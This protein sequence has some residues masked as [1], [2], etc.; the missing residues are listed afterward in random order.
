MPMD[1][2]KLN[3]R[4]RQF[5]KNTVQF[6]NEQPPKF[7]DKDK[8]AESAS[9]FSQASINSHEYIEAKDKIRQ[10]T[11]AD[12]PRIT[13]RSAYSP[14]DNAS[15]LVDELSYNKLNEMEQ[16]G[17]KEAKLKETPWS[18]D[19]WGIYKGMLGAR[20][21]D[22]DFP[23][24]Y[25][26]KTNA[27]Y[28]IAHPAIDILESRSATRINRLSPAEKYDALL[29][30]T[31]G[32]LT[33]A[34][35]MEG[36]RY[37]DA[38]G[39]VESWMGLCHGW[40]TAAYM[41]PRP[42]QAITL[43]SPDN[44]PIKFF[45][46][47]IKALGTL[48]WANAASRTKFIGGRCNDKEPETDAETGRITSE[49]CFDTNPG[50]WH[51]AIVNQIGVAKR[52]F[53]LDATFDYEVWNQ[54]AYA[55]EYT[56]FNPQTRQ[57]VDQL[58]DATISLD[59]YTNDKFKRFRSHKTRSVVGIAMTVT[60]VVETWP[61]QNETDSPE[62][63]SVQEVVYEYDLE[64]DENGVIIGGEWYRN[65]HPDFLWT[66]AKD[67]KAQT[68]FENSA[69]GSWNNVLRP[70]P[71]SWRAAA[72]QA[73]I[74]EKAAPL[75]KIVEQLIEFSTS[76]SDRGVPSS[77]GDNSTDTDTSTDNNGSTDTNNA[78]NAGSENNN[79]NNLGNSGNTSSNH[80]N[81]SPLSNLLNWI[82][83]LFGR[84]F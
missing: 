5:D 70:V 43:L 26:W 32:S 56:Y 20:Y 28:I 44:I 75:A 80:N 13:T 34:M 16:A 69:T 31:E 65:R 71:K 81:A 59:D 67:A 48:L 17:L 77:T 68:Q 50:T 15:N 25:D 10:E 36:K 19:Y 6:M 83:N 47:D 24:S 46:S 21:A 3:E 14:R 74:Q 62:N 8:P 63:D 18:D 4:L 1:K 66:P 33:Q 42:S 45:P 78:H 61:R 11:L 40:A 53:V 64:L 73:A 57:A 60:Y 39:E 35:W 49:R 7:V 29:G 22:P 55:Y 82:R 38:N 51:L 23:E 52:S 58:A 2:E 27:D 79:T 37:Y 76:S 30:D 84:M 9:L 54:P 72:K 41:L 12:A